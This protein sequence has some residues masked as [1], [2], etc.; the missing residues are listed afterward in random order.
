[1]YASFFKCDS[2][3]DMQPSPTLY[4]MFYLLLHVILDWS[5]RT[6]CNVMLIFLQEKSQFLQTRTICLGGDQYKKNGSFAKKPL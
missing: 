6:F 2:T 1:M 4:C 5:L 3:S